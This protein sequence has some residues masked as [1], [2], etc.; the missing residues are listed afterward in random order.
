M[1]ARH[2]SNTETVT[3]RHEGRRYRIERG[4]GL[5]AGTVREF[6]PGRGVI[7]SQRAWLGDRH[8]ARPTWYAAVNP[9]GQ[10]YR[11]TVRKEQL[12]S[13]RAAIRWLLATSAALGLPRERPI[14]CA[15]A[16]EG[17]PAHWR[18]PGQPCDRPGARRGGET[19]D[20]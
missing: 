13:R 1:A 15:H 19:G 4:P 14:L 6:W 5:Q 7:G 16:D 10:P 12:R 18:P 8:A 9:T 2:A 3:V 20:A 17:G 11:A